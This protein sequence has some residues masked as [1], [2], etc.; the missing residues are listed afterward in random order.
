[1][2]NT[3]IAE[4]LATVSHNL[5]VGS[6]ILDCSLPELNMLPPDAQ[7]KLILVQMGLSM[8]IDALNSEE[9]SPWIEGEFLSLNTL[10]AS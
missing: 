6:A 5:T 3:V 10:S 2:G 9:L 4:I 7:Q 8:A 1:M